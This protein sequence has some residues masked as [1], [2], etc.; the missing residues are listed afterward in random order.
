MCFWRVILD[1]S[2][3]E[4]L[5]PCDMPSLVRVLPRSCA[6]LGRDVVQ[7]ALRVELA[8]MP[9]RVVDAEERKLPTRGRRA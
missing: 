5:R 2:K 1:F 6:A 7:H 9:R 3:K 8:V 4:K